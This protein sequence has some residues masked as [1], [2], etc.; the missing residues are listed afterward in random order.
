MDSNKQNQPI[1]QEEINKVYNEW[2]PVID[3]F[4]NYPTT[5]NFQNLKYHPLLKDINLIINFDLKKINQ[6]L[7]LEITPNYIKTLK[8]NIEM[9][10]SIFDFLENEDKIYK[11]NF[12]VNSDKLDDLNTELDIYKTFGKILKVTIQKHFKLG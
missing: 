2:L 11:V 8:R 6:T 1:S 4:I 5:I 3:T 9:T 12:P 10:I 7:P